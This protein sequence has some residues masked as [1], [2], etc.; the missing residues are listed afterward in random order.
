MESLENANELI[1]DLTKQE[2]WDTLAKWV[3]AA[4]EEELKGIRLIK[5][6]MKHEGKK[7]FRAKQVK[8]DEKEIFKGDNIK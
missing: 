6:I 4:K 3:A 2:Y 8:K 7:K 5:A 1:R